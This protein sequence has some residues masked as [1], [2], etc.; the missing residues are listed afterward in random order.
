[1]EVLRLVMQT[2]VRD[3]V[4][5]MEGRAPGAF[6]MGLVDSAGSA[7]KPTKMGNGNRKDISSLTC[8][9]SCC[10]CMGWKTS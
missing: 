1:M 4:V 7:G 10:I 9:D 2:A 5:K 6:V 3:E 8:C